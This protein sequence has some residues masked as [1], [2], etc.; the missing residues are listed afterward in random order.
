[1]NKQ[2][3]SKLLT[4][5]EELKIKKDSVD[6]LSALKTVLDEATEVDGTIKI[7]IDRNKQTLSI[8]S[9]ILINY[10]NSQKIQIETEVDTLIDK[11]T[12]NG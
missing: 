8:P 2:K 10:V 12:I 9:T 7:T 6:L 5:F 11:V 1:M 4:A 3:Y